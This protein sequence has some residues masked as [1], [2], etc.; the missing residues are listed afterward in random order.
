MKI[1]KIISIIFFFCALVFLLIYWKTGNY[2]IG[3]FGYFSLVL[4]NI[5]IICVSVSAFSKKKKD[6]DK[7]KDK[8][9]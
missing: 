7:D 8:T 3:L 4:T 5:I 2:A 6:T 1:S 9:R